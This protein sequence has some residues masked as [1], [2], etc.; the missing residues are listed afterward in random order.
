MSPPLF[1]T[2]AMA[3][4]G[5]NFGKKKSCPIC[6]C[7][8]DD[9]PHLLQCISLKLKNADLLEKWEYSDIFLQNTMKQ[10]PVSLILEKSFRTRLEILDE[11]S[12]L[13]L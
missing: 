13:T 5:Y 3:L 6:L 7:G 4:V 9:Q 1:R 2:L 10:K 12:Q 8:A 11:A